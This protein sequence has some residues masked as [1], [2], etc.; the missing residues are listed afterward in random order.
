MRANDLRKEL[1]ESVK[2]LK[3]MKDKYAKMPSRLVTRT[4]K[5]T[6]EHG[7]A[8]T[9]AKEVLQNLLNKVWET[10]ESTDATDTTP[11]IS[12]DPNHTQPDIDA[13]RQLEQDGGENCTGS[14]NQQPIEAAQDGDSM[15]QREDNPIV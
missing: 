7:N 14:N 15:K 8:E 1:Q 6:I 4:S 10:V 3:E 12:G 9:V 11:D 2:R 5:S 13:D